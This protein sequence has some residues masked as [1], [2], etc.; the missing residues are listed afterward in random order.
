MDDI[1]QVRDDLN[2]VRGVITRRSPGLDGIPIIY[3][4]SAVYVLIGYFLL[5]VNTTWANWYFIIAA[6]V[7][8]LVL[9]LYFGPAK[10]RA[11]EIDRVRYRQNVLHWAVG[12]WG[13]MI[14][15]TALACVVPALRGPTGGQVAVLLIGMVYFMWGI[16]RDRSFLLLGPLLMAG[17]VVVGLIPHYPW[18]CLGALGALGLMTAGLAAQR[19]IARRAQLESSSPQS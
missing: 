17:G 13:S 12:I 9:R 15:T 1:Q 4:C 3:Y 16:Y 8:T 5:D 11:G 2:F 6:I 10:L 18:T 19:S 7:G 14:A